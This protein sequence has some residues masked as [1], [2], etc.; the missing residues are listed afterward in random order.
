VRGPP[1]TSQDL[2]LR[3]NTTRRNRQQGQALVEFAILLPVLLLLLLGIV[4]FGLAFNNYIQVTSAAREGARKASVSRSLGSSAAATAART[5][6]KGAAPNLNLQDSQITV[7]ASGAWAQGTEV[8]VTVKYPY[9]IDILGRVVKS[10]NLSASSR[11][12]IE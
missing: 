9:S 6:A 8:E 7:T 5:A 3:S 11:F 10:G 2:M 4:Q 12:R 1:F